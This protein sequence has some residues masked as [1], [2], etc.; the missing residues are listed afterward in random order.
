[1]ALFAKIRP[2][3]AGEKIVDKFGAITPS[4]GLLWQQLFGNGDFLDVTKVGTE[5]QIIAGTGLTG[6][7]D[8]SADRT[9]AIDLT[10]EAERIR[11]V[12]GTALVAGTNITI[13]VD[14]AGNTITI[15]SSGGGASTGGMR[16]MVTGSSPPVFITGVGNDL[17]MTEV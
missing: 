13:T 1:M 7:G 16:P 6:G 3:Q 2:L 9:L 4:F 5:R 12:M 11:D 15:A 17:I 10:T 14:D 8:L